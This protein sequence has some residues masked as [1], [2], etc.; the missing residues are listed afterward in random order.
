MR[1]ARDIRGFRCGN[2]STAQHRAEADHQEARFYVSPRNLIE[3][4]DP[5]LGALL[6]RSLNGEHVDLRAHLLTRK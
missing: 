4:R 3:A 6:R 5:Q 2:V 1:D